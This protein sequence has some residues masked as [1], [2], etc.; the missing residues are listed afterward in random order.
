MTSPYGVLRVACI[1]RVFYPTGFSPPP[2]ETAIACVFRAVGFSLARNALN[3]GNLGCSLQYRLLL[4]PVRRLQWLQRNGCNRL[5][6]QG[7]YD[8]RR[9]ASLAEAPDRRRRH[10]HSK[11]GFGLGGRRHHICRPGRHID[12]K[13]NVLGGQLMGIINQQSGEYCRHQHNDR[14]F[15]HSFTRYAYC[16]F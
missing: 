8:P 13:S 9:V 11:Y 2:L 3:D 5:V 4:E 12:R 10:L 16:G 1:T 14:D 7:P 6:G 15:P